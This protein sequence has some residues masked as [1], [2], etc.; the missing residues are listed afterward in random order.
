MHKKLNKKLILHWSLVQSEHMQIA[1]G[2]LAADQDHL[3]FETETFGIEPWSEKTPNLYEIRLRLVCGEQELDRVNQ[4]FGMRYARRE[5]TQIMINNK[6]VF[7]R[8]TTEH[9]YFPESCTVPNDFSY[10]M[11]T[12]KEIKRA[13][14]NWMRFHTAIPPEECMEAADRLGMY[15]QAETQNGFEDG[16]FINMIKLCRR[17][18]SV[19]LYCCGNEVPIDDQME[20][21]LERMGEACHTLAPDCLYDPME[22]LLHVE[23]R[24]DETDPGYTK[25]PYEHNER[26]LARMR[27]YSD[28]FAAGVWVFSYHS[29]YPDVNAI[30]NRLSMYQ[31]PCLIHEAGIF[32]TYL[33]L[34]L[35]KRYEKRLTWL[36]MDDNNTVRG[37]G[38]AEVSDVKNGNLC[39]LAEADVGLDTVS[40]YGEH[41]RLVVTLTGGIY[42]ISNEWDYWVF[43]R[44]ETPRTNAVRIADRL[45]EEDVSYMK[46]G[47]RMILMGAG[48]FPGVPISF[49]IT[50]GGRTGG[51][52]ATVIYDHP[53]MRDFPQDGF[54]DWQFAEMFHDGGAVQFNDLELAF[55]PIVEIVSTYKFIRKQAA[56]FEIKIGKGAILV[57]TLII[58]V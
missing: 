12:L 14:F 2:S 3:C 23:C 22:A 33:N 7:L 30:N 48:P 24:L 52:N 9:A 20:D 47:G 4:M 53:I 19:I 49:Q 13:G 27:T 46:N 57:C 36:L 35:E 5:G 34:D 29:L 43:H 18:P 45:T 17:H 40:G 31:R 25:E 26:K 41:V 1:S 38:S 28:V 51:N 16:D 50:P 21:Q 8:G 39:E 55:R 54:C 10:Y 56:L 44:C 37:S 42:H 6:P 58:R 15:I 11:R 32:D